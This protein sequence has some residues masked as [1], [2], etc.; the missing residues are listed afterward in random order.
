MINDTTRHQNE[1]IVRFGYETA[2]L[3]LMVMRVGWGKRPFVAKIEA[4]TVHLGVQGDLDLAGNRAK[5]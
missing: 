2:V 4:N 3:F 1:K 5:Y